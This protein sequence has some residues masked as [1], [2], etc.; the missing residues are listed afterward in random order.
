M[1]KEM[2][3][4]DA[5]QK[6]LTDL[7]GHEELFERIWDEKTM[8]REEVIY[9]YILKRLIANLKDIQMIEDQIKEL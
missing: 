4:T 9:N 7:Y 3:E 1:G 5:N 8:S 6:E 2:R